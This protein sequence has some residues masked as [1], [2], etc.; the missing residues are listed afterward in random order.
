M[1]NCSSMRPEK[2]G[3]NSAERK[4]QSCS[5]PPAL[6]PSL[7]NP[8]K[9]L[10]ASVC[11]FSFPVAPYPTQSGLCT[12]HLL[13][14]LSPRSSMPARCQ[15][16]GHLQD[17]S[18]LLNNLDMLLTS[19]SLKLHISTGV[20]PS[21]GDS[22]LWLFRWLHPLCHLWMLLWLVLDLFLISTSSL[23]NSSIPTASVWY[24]QVPIT[25]AASP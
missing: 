1:S 7:R 2:D 20:L 22:P 21:T 16:N 17:L 9:V 13:E 25:S 15:P 14:T 12:H 10:M 23:G 19:F 4:A 24:V 3:D 6:S 8:G 11:T 18:S 5:V